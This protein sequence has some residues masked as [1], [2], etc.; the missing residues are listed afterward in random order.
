LILNDILPLRV[1]IRPCAYGHFAAARLIFD[2]STSVKIV[3]FWI[4]ANIYERFMFLDEDAR[5][6]VTDDCVACK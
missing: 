6:E 1:E 5:V 2:P 3:R 4:E